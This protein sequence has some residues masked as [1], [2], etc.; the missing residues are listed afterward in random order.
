M[1]KAFIILTCIFASTLIGKSQFFIGGSVG[2]DAQGG[3]TENNDNST[4]SES[5][6]SYSLS[7]QFGFQVSEKMDIGAYLT[8]AHDHTNN[9][10]DPAYIT[11]TLSLGFSP[12]LRYYAF[13]HNKFSIYG[14][15]AGIYDFS[16][17]KSE[18][19]STEFD[20][21]KTVMLGFI[22]YPGMSYKLGEK[23]QLMAAI[24]LFSLGLIHDIEKTGDNKEID[25]NFH[26]GVNMD[27]ILTTGSVSIGAIYRF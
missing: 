11:N 9:N 22:A 10:L 27:H 16:V 25:T 23:V 2:F 7:P 17:E 21:V 12:Y 6:F 18:N 4:K 24:N 19:G 20:D 3:K 1:K 5:S 14:E 8:Y 13:T 26:F 15:F